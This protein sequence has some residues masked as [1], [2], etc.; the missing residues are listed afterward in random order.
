MVRGASSVVFVLLM[1]QILH[2][3]GIVGQMQ[4]H[5]A[6]RLMVKQVFFHQLWQAA[7]E[8]KAQTEVRVEAVC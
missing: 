7:K 5:P 1:E 8:A 4:C 3:P 6:V 2:H